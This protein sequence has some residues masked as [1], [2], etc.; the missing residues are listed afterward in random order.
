MVSHCTK[1]GIGCLNGG[2]CVLVTDQSDGKTPAN[3]CKCPKGTSGYHCDRKGVCPLDCQHDS[4]C[5]HGDDMA[6]SNEGGEFY[7]ECA[8][9]SNYKGKLCQVP[10][11]T[12]PKTNDDDEPMQCLFGGECKLSSAIFKH[13]YC[14]CPNGR[15]GDRCEYG[16]TSSIEDYNG[17]C[18]E[19]S[20]CKNGGVCIHKY[21]SNATA[22]TGMK[23]KNTYCQCKDGFG[24]DWCQLSCES[25]SCQH[26]SS[27][28]FRATYAS[29]GD[30]TH[31]NDVKDSGAYCDCANTGLDGKQKG[32]YKG[33]ECDI[34]VQVCPGDDE[35]MECLYGG[36]CVGSEE[37]NDGNFY[38]CNCPT[39]RK[40]KHCEILIDDKGTSMNDKKSYGGKPNNVSKVYNNNDVVLST[41]Q[42]LIP[43]K[44]VVIG[45]VLVGCFLIVAIVLGLMMRKKRNRRKQSRETQRAVAESLDDTFTANANDENNNNVNGMNNE[46]GGGGD[47]NNDD[48]GTDDIVNI[49]LSD[50]GPPHPKKEIV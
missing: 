10:Y 30:I 49:S 34:E 28:R 44:D 23:T 38:N 8:V 11:T 15:S 6:H 33:L 37:D 43:T 22:K 32:K 36:V 13:Y 20:D 35:T 46:D 12:C 4:S 9:G 42:Q 2:V 18:Y 48:N 5:R 25:L 50:D 19:D 16:K 24:G 41:Q 47:I 3:Y 21:D 1:D 7:C 45:A 39:N 14:E 29:G 26:G 40:G 17:S 31:A 27:C